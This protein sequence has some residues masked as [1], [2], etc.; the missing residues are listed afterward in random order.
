MPARSQLR[1]SVLRRSIA[2]LGAFGLAV[3]AG[4]CAAASGTSSS[5]T[6][7]AASSLA[8]ATAAGAPASAPAS[9]DAASAGLQGVAAA[10]GHAYRLTAPTRFPGT[11]PDLSARLSQAFGTAM[12]YWQG[13]LPR[14]PEG[15]QY[16][17]VLSTAAGS[18]PQDRFWVNIGFL[19]GTTADQMQRGVNA[20]GNA[21]QA[22]DMPR[23]AAQAALDRCAR[24]DLDVVYDLLVPDTSGA[25]IWVLST[26]AGTRYSGVAASE[27]LVTIAD[28]AESIYGS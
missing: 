7:P 13:H 21:C 5:A 1:S 9:E 23:A 11:C 4:G 17:T 15:C 16:A 8:T 14:G 18:L 19:T 10:I 20:S 22:V 12:T 27:A 3:L 2:A 24:G 28:A 6:P 26:G 25:G